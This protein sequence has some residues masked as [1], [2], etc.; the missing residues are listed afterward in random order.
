MAGLVTIV[1][2]LS[3]SMSVLIMVTVLCQVYVRAKRVGQE[4][5]A[6]IQSALKNAIMVEPALLLTHANVCSGKISGE[7]DGLGMEFL[8]FRLHLEIPN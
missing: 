4:K 1:R 3:V 5:I 7:M 6:P 2:Y 8:Y